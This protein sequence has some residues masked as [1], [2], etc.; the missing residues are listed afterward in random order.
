MQVAIFLKETKE[1]HKPERE[2]ALPDREHFK[3]RGPNE[4]HIRGLPF[5]G[6]PLH[7]REVGRRTVA[8]PSWWMNLAD[9][10][11]IRAGLLC[12]HSVNLSKWLV[13]LTSL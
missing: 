4:H 8:H 7:T 5:A 10:Q 2:A 12:T 1:T 13:S 6:A 9:I 3:P 11:D